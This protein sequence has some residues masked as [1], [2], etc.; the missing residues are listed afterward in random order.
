M[1]SLHL[2]GQSG[3]RQDAGMSVASG[4]GVEP[5]PIKREQCMRTVTTISPFKIR[6]TAVSRASHRAPFTVVQT[7]LYYHFLWTIPAIH[8]CYNPSLSRPTHFDPK[9]D[10]VASFKTFA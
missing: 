5:N 1:H 3:I 6:R 4:Q 9:M 2:Q 8:L 10:V 7:G